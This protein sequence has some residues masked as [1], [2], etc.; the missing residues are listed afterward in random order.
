MAY[1]ANDGMNFDLNPAT[2]DNFELGLKTDNRFGA[3]TAAL[4]QSETRNDIVSDATVDGR[5]TYKNADKTLRQGAELSWNKALWRDLTAQASYS[6]IDATFDADVPNAVAAKV[7]K[8]GNAIPGV[9]KNQGFVALAWQPET[10]FN[11]GVDVRYMDKI[12]VDDINSDSAPSYTVA[13]ANIGY[14]WKNNDWKV[15]SFA[16]VDNLFDENYAGSVIVN[17]G[18]GR[19]FE[20]ADGLN[21]SAG[22]SITKAF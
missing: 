14:V 11:A 20:P 6:F 12:Y 15:R 19:F 7:V 17:D 4:F 2:S 13:S 10:G 9:A 22:L 1:S 8:S 21:W 18:N 16:R 3:F 5:A